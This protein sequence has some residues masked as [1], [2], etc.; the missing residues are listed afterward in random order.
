[1]GVT[2]PERNLTDVQDGDN[3][4]IERSGADFR[5]QPNSWPAYLISKGFL[6]GDNTA[7]FATNQ[8]DDKKW[9]IGQKAIQLPFSTTPNNATPNLLQSQTFFF[10]PSSTDFELQPPSNAPSGAQLGST[11]GCMYFVIYGRNASS[12]QSGKLTFGSNYKRLP[13][14]KPW[15]NTGNDRT[16]IIH[17]WYSVPNDVV[18]YRIDN[19]GFAEEQ[20]IPFDVTIPAASVGASNATPYEII[21]APGAG[22][23]A[24]VESCWSGLVN[25]SSLYTGNVNGFVIHAGQT[26]GSYGVG[27]ANLASLIVRQM[28]TVSSGVCDNLSNIVDQAVNYQTITGD[29]STGDYDLRI[30]GAYRKLAA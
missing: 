24:N 11:A 10:Q 17:C 2:I 16:N 21:P 18:Y 7:M 9:Q 26:L 23:F 20:L 19:I 3:L 1:M 5:V 22:L 15:I 30:W 28:A 13:G 8:S 6:I 27:T 12:G 29:P 14:S 25:G 4:P